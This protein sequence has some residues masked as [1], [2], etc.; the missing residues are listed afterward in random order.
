[1]SATISD[2]PTWARLPEQARNAQTYRRGDPGLRTSTGPDRRRILLSTAI[3][4]M[5]LVVIGSTWWVTL[6][7]Y[8]DAPTLVNMTKD[9][10]ELYAKE[11]NFELFYGAGAY[12][13]SLPKD[14]VVNQ[15]PGPQEKIV[16]GGT[17]TLTLSLGKERF[18]VP[19][20]TG[21]ELAAA[22]TELA[23]A[24]LKYKEGAG[25]Y[26]DTVPEGAVLSTNPAKGTELKRGDT[27]TV[28]TSKGRA[29]ISVPDL[30]GKNINDA[31]NQ[32]QTLGLTA[33]ERY[34]DSNEP[35]DTVIAQTPKPGTGAANDAEV[36]LD[37]SK[38]P[39][40]VTVPDLTNQQCQ[41]AVAALQ[42]QGLQP[43]VTGFNQNGFVRGQNPPGNTPVAPGSQVVIQC[44]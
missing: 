43:Q 8:T 20:L 33:V 14:T 29:P 19:D 24:N 4:V 44:F 42:Q 28:V 38:G 36:T 40:Q 15:N 13:E 21:V 30:V 37:V 25:Q 5:V 12:S 10:A 26:S 3:A 18:E 7:R 9:Q 2:R 27:V 34:K 39:P 17:I 35:A 16:K 23:Q 22:K 11:H 41:Q 32:L 31:R 6:G 1:V